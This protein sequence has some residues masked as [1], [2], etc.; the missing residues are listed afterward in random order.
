M[1][2]GS[3]KGEFSFL[4]PSGT[5]D[6]NVYSESPDAG[7]ARPQDAPLTMP[8]FIHGLRLKVPDHQDTLDLGVLFVE[9]GDGKN[10][11]PRG[12]YSKH[13][14]QEPPASRSPTPA[15]SIET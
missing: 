6:L 5:Y 1:F 12:D 3:V 15:E 2:C 11:V 10:G 4:L 13:Y 8:Q 9:F 7:I 14:G